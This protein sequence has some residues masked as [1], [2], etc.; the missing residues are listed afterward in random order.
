VNTGHGV[1]LGRLGGADA[2]RRISSRV[3]KGTLTGFGGRQFPVEVFAKA[4]DKRL[5]VMH[6][7]N[8]DSITAYDGR[9]GW[10]GNVSTIR[11]E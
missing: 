5:S 7:P 9:V 10:L 3:E 11:H 2:L 1:L 6:L 4:A 8:G